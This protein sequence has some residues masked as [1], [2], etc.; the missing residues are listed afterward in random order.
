MDQSMTR[1]MGIT[2][3]LMVLSFVVVLGACDLLFGPEIICGPL[4]AAECGEAVEAIQLT[5]GR[6]YP[7]RRV[8][9]IEFVNEEGHASIRLDDGTEIG[10]GERL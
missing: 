3:V 9:F 8:V 1:R 6:E 5:L 2:R 4:E 7:N 10:W